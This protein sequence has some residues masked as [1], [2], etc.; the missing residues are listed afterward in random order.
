MAEEKEECWKASECEGPSDFLVALLM[1]WFLVSRYLLWVVGWQDSWWF[2]TSSWSWQLSFSMEWFEVQF[3][4]RSRGILG[5]AEVLQ[6]APAT[7]VPVKTIG[8][9]L[10]M[11]IPNCSSILHDGSEAAYSMLGQMTPS[12]SCCCEWWSG[13]L[14][15]FCVLRHWSCLPLET[16]LECRCPIADICQVKIQVF[17]NDYSVKGLAMEYWLMIIWCFLFLMACMWHTCFALKF[18]YSLLM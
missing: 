1:A 17:S 11:R 3:W 15:C 2:H 12:S 18:W 4:D 14:W 5:Q 6:N 16:L 13:S 7:L 10:L 9:H 8:Q